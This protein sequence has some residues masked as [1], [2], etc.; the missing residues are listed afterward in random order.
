MSTIT[1]ETLQLKAEHGLDLKA[2][3]NAFEA[4]LKEVNAVLVEGGEGKK[5]IIPGKGTATVTRSSEPEWTGEYEH[6]FDLAAFEKL[7]A[8]LRNRL[9]IEGVITLKKKMKGGSNS[10]VRYTINA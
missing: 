6:V 7:N 9:I 10:T 1:I 2:K 5:Y 8:A 4:E 3:L